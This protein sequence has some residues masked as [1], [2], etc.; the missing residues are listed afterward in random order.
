MPK[1]H[2]YTSELLTGRC[3]KKGNS[4]LLK[5]VLIWTRGESEMASSREISVY[6]TKRLMVSRYHT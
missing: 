1:Y 3:G 6:V 5:C 2:Y 4:L